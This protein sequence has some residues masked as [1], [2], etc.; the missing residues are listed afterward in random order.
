MKNNAIRFLAVLITVTAALMAAIAAINRG[1]TFVEQGLLVVLSVI[2]VLGVHLLPAISR[3]VPSWVLW[4]GCLLCAIYGH[5]TFL[6]H[7]TL[8]AGQARV[9]Q[10]VQ[11]AGT[12]RQIDAV[13]ESL[14]AISARPVT[15]V[16]A[17]LAQT[18]DW[19]ARI[20]LKEELSQAKRADSLRNELMR[21]N[22]VAAGA[23][24]ANSA[25]PVISRIMAVTGFSEAGVTLGIGMLFSVLLELVGTF[26][27]FEA[28]KD[29]PSMTSLICDPM[30]DPMDKPQVTH[31]V[32]TGVTTS[33]TR[34]MT[35]HVTQVMDDAAR[36][37]EAIVNGECRATVA[38]IRA[39][40]HC[41]QN[42]AMELRREMRVV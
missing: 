7:S 22:E 42:R 26:L 14:G 18:K 40:L 11:L 35:T 41:S 34:S 19:Q 6:T 25:D 1:G 24:T 28:L 5:L 36:L 9:Q 32:T 3:R 38:S 17:E 12:Q 31:S 21:L 15:I 8:G 27:W 29:R 4:A 20:A 39:F 10:S 16:A 33:V 30:S 23:V 13:R 2:M 37:R